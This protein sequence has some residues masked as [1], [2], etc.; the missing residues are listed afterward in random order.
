MLCGAFS[1]VGGGTDCAVSRVGGAVGGA[2]AFVGEGVARD[3]AVY[4][5]TS[6]KGF[7]GGCGGAV[8]VVGV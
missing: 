8:D 3:G 2:E 1:A 5:R 7:G 4:C 6:E